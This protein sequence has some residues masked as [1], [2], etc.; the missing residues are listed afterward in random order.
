MQKAACGQRVYV[1][2]DAAGDTAKLASHTSVTIRGYGLALQA[3]IARASHNAMRK[4]RRAGDDARATADELSW[5]QS[6]QLR[7]A[8]A[9]PH[10][11][12]FSPNAAGIEEGY[13]GAPTGPS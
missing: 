1:A 9:P 13:D 11:A 7:L 10:W 3:A 5:R 2:G 12:R 4:P 6:M 8:L